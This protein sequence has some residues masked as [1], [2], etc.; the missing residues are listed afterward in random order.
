LVSPAGIKVYL[1]VFFPGD[2]FTKPSERDVLLTTHLHLDHYD[3]YGR[4]DDDFPGAKLTAAQGQMRVGDV[5]I[6]SILSQHM[7]GW[8]MP[9]YIMV[10]DTGGLRVAHFGDI[11]QDELTAEQLEV[12]KGVDIAFMQFIEAR[13]PLM[14]Q[15]RPKV[16][17]PTHFKI[18]P[19]ELAF[20]RW[21]SYR[22]GY[23]FRVSPE[24]LSSGLPGERTRFVVM[25]EN[26]TPG[27]LWLDL[28]PVNAGLRHVRPLPRPVA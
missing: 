5:T 12:V 1:D 14:E 23:T 7:Y 11:G 8:D 17:V 3:Y 25:G 10:I 27:K 26:A 22:T 4:F 20:N 24:T 2:L 28:P 9:N 15:L 13:L 19:A 6:K 16:I 18:D 21:P